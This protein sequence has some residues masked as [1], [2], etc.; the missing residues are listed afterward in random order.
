MGH[1]LLKA[2]PIPLILILAVAW[3]VFP[4]GEPQR[5]G[6]EAVPAVG[7]SREMVLDIVR[8]DLPDAKRYTLIIKFEPGGNRDPEVDR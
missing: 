7:E 6:A 3:S 5:P 1:L 2:I 8:T 4:R